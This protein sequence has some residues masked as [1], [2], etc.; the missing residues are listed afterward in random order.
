MRKSARAFVTQRL[1]GSSDGGPKIQQS[2]KTTSSFR[3][4]TSHVRLA[5]KRSQRAA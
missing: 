4:V 5:G 1:N 2:I 3:L